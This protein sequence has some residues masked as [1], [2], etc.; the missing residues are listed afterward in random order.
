M[1]L[2]AQPATVQTYDELKLKHRIRKQTEI[3]LHNTYD[4]GLYYALSS[5]FTSCTFSALLDADILQRVK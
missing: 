4:V 5:N 3:Q 1:F 2:Y